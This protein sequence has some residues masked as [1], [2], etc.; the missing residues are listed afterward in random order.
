MSAPIYVKSMQPYFESR[1]PAAE[2]FAMGLGATQLRSLYSMVLPDSTRGMASASL[3][4][5]SRALSTLA[6]CP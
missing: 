1:D 3:I 6:P 2:D 5:M 4:A